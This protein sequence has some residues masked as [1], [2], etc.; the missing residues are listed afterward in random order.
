MLRSLIAIKYDY[1]DGSPEDPILLR[2]SFGI[3]VNNYMIMLPKFDTGF[4]SK[5]MDLIRKTIISYVRIS[6]KNYGFS[7][8]E[9]PH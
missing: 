3:E 5:H 2:I 8:S 7:T 4:G 6:T 9:V 1:Y